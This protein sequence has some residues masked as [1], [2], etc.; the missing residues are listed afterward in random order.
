MLVGNRNA[1]Y[2]EMNLQGVKREA[3]A[4]NSYNTMLDY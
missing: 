1:D 3:K 2:L 4:C